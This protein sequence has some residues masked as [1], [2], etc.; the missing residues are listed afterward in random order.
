MVD[1]QIAA[2]GVNAGPVLEAMREVPRHLFVPEHLRSEAYADRP[3]AIGEGQ[4]ISQPYM[5]AIMTETL[6]ARPTDRVLEIGTGSGYQ[7]AILARLAHHVVSIE[8][9]AVLAERARQTLDLVGAT[10]VEIVVGDGTEGVPSRA[11]FDR[12]LVT[13]GA[14]SVPDTLRRQLADGGRLII[15]V[16]PSGF[17]RL[18]IVEREGDGYSTHEGEAC[19]FVPLIGVHGWPER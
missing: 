16:G 17:Q 7:T 5:V 3:L 18:V 14:P 15:P 1:T 11:P 2:R 6:A 4:T 13:A 9:H 8:R 10:N 19:V 12:I